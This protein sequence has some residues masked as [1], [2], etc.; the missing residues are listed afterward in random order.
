M[1]AVNNSTIFRNIHIKIYIENNKRKNLQYETARVQER[2]T[3]TIG[4]EKRSNN[5]HSCRTHSHNMLPHASYPKMFIIIS[6]HIKQK[7][8]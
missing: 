3:E 1:A 2:E 5:F 8:S 6:N 4:E 7:Q